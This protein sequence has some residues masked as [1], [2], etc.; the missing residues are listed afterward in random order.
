MFQNGYAW[1]PIN[2]T[3]PSALQQL[4]ISGRS[5]SQG[6]PSAGIQITPAPNNA[7]NGGTSQPQ[8]ALPAPTPPNQQ[9]PANAN[10]QRGTGV[11]SS[12]VSGMPGDVGQQGGAPV[13][14]ASNQTNI[15]NA[16]RAQSTG[17]APAAAN[18]P[19]PRVA[20]IQAR[21]PYVPD[22]IANAYLNNIIPNWVLGIVN[23]MGARAQA[24][25][26]R[27]SGGGNALYAP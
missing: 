15:A 24:S 17:G 7:Q 18:T 26:T 25:V 12:Q 23:D 4:L 9:A 21:M 8:A 11:T 10:A 6:N 16:L 5:A 13:A 27:P 19:D 2:A 1:G 22:I 14:G 20:A 3:D